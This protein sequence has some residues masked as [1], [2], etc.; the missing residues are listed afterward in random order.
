VRRD[1]LDRKYAPLKFLSQSLMT[2]EW[3]SG[4][5][6]R[7]DFMLRLLRIACKLPDAGRFSRCD[8]TEI[9]IITAYFYQLAVGLADLGGIWHVTSPKYPIAKASGCDCAL[10]TGNWLR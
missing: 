5:E 1:Q 10:E 4:A 2:L 3:T 9:G 8:A 6:M 7:S